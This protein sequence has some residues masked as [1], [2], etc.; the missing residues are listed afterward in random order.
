MPF[1]TGDLG[2]WDMAGNIHYIG[3]KDNEVKQNGYRINLAEIT[4]TLLRCEGVT[5]AYTLQ[6]NGQLL[7]VFKGLTKGSQS[8]SKIR[9]YLKKNLPSYMIPQQLVR[10]NSGVPLTNNGKVDQRKLVSLIDNQSQINSESGIERNKLSDFGQVLLKELQNLFSNMSISL[11]DNFFSLGG[12]SIKAIQL[13]TKLNDLGYKLS[14]DQLYKHNNIADLLQLPIRFKA[15]SIQIHED[16]TLEANE[17]PVSKMQQWLLSRKT[18]NIDHRNLSLVVSLDSGVDIETI[19]HRIVDEVNHDDAFSIAI[20]KNKMGR[21]VNVQSR[22]LFTE[23][24]I[25]HFLDLNTAVNDLENSL[26][27]KDGQLLN[28]GYVKQRAR[29]YFVFV[30]HQTVMDYFSWRIFIKNIFST[31]QRK[32]TVSFKNWL[33]ENNQQELPLPQEEVAYWD[34]KFAKAKKDSR[35]SF[36]SE[37]VIDVKMNYQQTK[38]LRC[39]FNLKAQDIDSVLLT[40]FVKSYCETFNQDTLLVMMGDHGRDRHFGIDST[41]VV[42]RCSILFPCELNYDHADNISENYLKVKDSYEE[43]KL[44]KYSYFKYFSDVSTDNAIPTVSFNYM[45]NFETAIRNPID[46][47][48]KVSNQFSEDKDISPKEQYIYNLKFS[49]Y[50][51]KE[52]FFLKVMFN[53]QHFSKKDI[54]SLLDLFIKNTDEMYEEIK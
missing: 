23:R 40:L 43:A 9:A 29:N 51:N 33:N 39:L 1:T 46:K 4:G 37:K 48:M 7:S 30:C 12:D 38:E 54:H 10:V 8:I 2:Y 6:H 28:V 49:A 24:D 53:K 50:Q 26:S 42:G 21:W 45:G 19:K 5:Q 14:L 34:T 22:Q 13:C 47:T 36:K 25:K 15:S 35:S 31:G 17:T 11:E 27:L 3:R 18:D 32:T 20:V 41:R 52:N 16:N 44:H